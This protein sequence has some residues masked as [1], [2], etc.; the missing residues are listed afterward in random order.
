MRT[1][2]YAPA[3][4]LLGLALMSAC[5]TDMEQ[6]AAKGAATGLLLAGPVGTAAGK[7]AGPVTS[8]VKENNR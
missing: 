6:R 3:V 2:L 8:E 1:I 4:A 5:G 7:A